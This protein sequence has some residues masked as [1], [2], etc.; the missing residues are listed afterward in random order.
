MPR[1]AIDLPEKVEYLSI[2]DEKGRLDKTLEPQI[3]GDTLI[4]L[5]DT[6]L[7]GRRFDE[8]LLSLQRQGRI[9]TF[10]PIKGQEAAQLGA[11]ARS[12]V[13]A[14]VLTAPAVPASPPSARRLRTASTTP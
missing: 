10:P 5:Y 8:R 2:L 1:K 3:P 12:C 13:R 6:M 14:V 4:K 7:M 9:G 11:V